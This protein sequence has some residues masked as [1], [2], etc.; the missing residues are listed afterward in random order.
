[1]GKILKF[2]ALAILFAALAFAAYVAFVLWQHDMFKTPT[3]DE[4]PPEVT[5]V[6]DRPN[7]LVFSKTNNFRHIEAI[8]QVQSLF[9]AL[10]ERENWNVVTS[11]N[12]AIHNTEALGRFD[13]V[14]W[15]NVTG[16]V[17][18][19]EQRAAF[20]GFIETGGQVL[21]IHG[22]GGTPEYQWDWHPKEFI[23]ARFNAHPLT[24]QFQEATLIIDDKTHPATAHLPGGW[25]LTDEWYSFHNNPRARVNVL[26]SLDENT[27]NPSKFMSDGKLRMGD[28]PIVWWHTLGKGRVFYSAIGHRAELY[29]DENYRQLLEEA[30][31]WLIDEIP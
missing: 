21:A 6:Q 22:S 14:V 7:I 2:G 31:V 12:A 9:A 24:A 17:L 25:Q 18:T 26:I 5:L 4:T 15:N 20:K 10:S 23:R 8:P 11:D 29:H 16:D 19:L 30:A 13:L 3:Y 27:Y 1:M 28:H